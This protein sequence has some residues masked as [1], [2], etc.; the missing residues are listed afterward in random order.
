MTTKQTADHER[1]D[2]LF[3]ASFVA[4]AICDGYKDSL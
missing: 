1:D 3:A 4:S 2:G